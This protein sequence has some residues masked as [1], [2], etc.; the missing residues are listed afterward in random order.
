MKIGR[1][2]VK[3]KERL[4]RPVLA[5][6]GGERDGK[7]ARTARIPGGRMSGAEAGGRKTAATEASPKTASAGPAAIRAGAK[8]GATGAN[9]VQTGTRGVP[10]DSRGVPA[11]SGGARRV[12]G[13]SQVEEETLKGERGALRAAGSTKT[14]QV[15]TFGTAAAQ[16]ER[17]IE[18]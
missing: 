7:R 6:L 12:G 4:P 5:R 1:Q 10:E 11:K 18:G 14:T 15:G 3:R 13:T 8:T 9:E 17:L 2:P 16:E